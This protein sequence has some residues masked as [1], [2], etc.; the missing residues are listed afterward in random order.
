MLNA[1]Y[2]HNP[3]LWERGGGLHYYTVILLYCK[4]IKLMGLYGSQR[5]G[6]LF[7]FIVLRFTPPTLSHKTGLESIEFQ[8]VVLAL[9]AGDC[10]NCPVAG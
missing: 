10:D 2:G 3:V 7:S 9:P 1:K 8:P 6:G 4:T 5:L